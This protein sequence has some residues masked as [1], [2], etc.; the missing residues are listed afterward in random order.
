LVL[1]TR[2]DLSFEVNVLLVV[3]GKLDTQLIYFYF[4]GL[5]WRRE[6]LYDHVEDGGL[7]RYQLVEEFSYL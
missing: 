5:L 1:V 7:K 3:S 4:L 2:S 6:R